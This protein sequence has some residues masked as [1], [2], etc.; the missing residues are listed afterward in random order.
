MKTPLVV[1][2]ATQPLGHQN[3]NS[4][5]LDE[6]LALD[7]ECPFS[8]AGAGGGSIESVLSAKNKLLLVHQS[9]QLLLVP[10]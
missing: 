10:E 3:D 8:P 6:V 1:G 4:E 2:C 5:G 9:E 7:G